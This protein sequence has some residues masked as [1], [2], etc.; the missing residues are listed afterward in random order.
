MSPLSSLTAL[1][2]VYPKST[3]SIH[4]GEM[5][6]LTPLSS[7]ILFYFCLSPIAFVLPPHTSQA[8]SL[9]L[10]PSFSSCPVR[11]QSELSS[12]S[13]PTHSS[14]FTQIPFFFLRV[15][16][17][18]CSLCFFPIDNF[19]NCRTAFASEG[20]DMLLWTTVDYSTALITKKKGAVI[21]QLLEKITIRRCA[22]MLYY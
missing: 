8:L 3:C 10:F 11:T 2:N 19:C 12:R 16:F 5:F 7:A 13:F 17:S 21:R 14:T 9:S 20:D 15:P 22:G 4:K 1:V 6:T 18:L